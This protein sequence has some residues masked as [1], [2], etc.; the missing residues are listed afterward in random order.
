MNE[1]R[2]RGLGRGGESV[3]GVCVDVM[4]REKIERVRV[5]GFCKFCF[6]ETVFAIFET[7]HCDWAAA[8]PRSALQ[9]ARDGGLSDCMAR[10]RSVRCQL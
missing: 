5:G 1:K 4:E 6:C 8:G 7:R 3:G 2:E 10:E 9:Y